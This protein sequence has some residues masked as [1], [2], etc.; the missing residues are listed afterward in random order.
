[1]VQLYI[2][3]DGEPNRVELFKDETISLTQ[4]ITN[5]QDAGKLFAD[6]S[7]SF[8]I[9]ASPTNNRIFK[10][11]YE[12]SVQNGFDHRYRYDGFI[13]INTIPFKFGGLQLN[14][15][16]IKD[17]KVYSYKVTFFGNVKQIKDLFGDDKLNSL[18]YSS[19]NHAYNASEILTRI[20]SSSTYA[21]RYPLFG[22]GR[23]L[24]YGGGGS[25]DV[26]TGSG[27]I[28]WNSLF[29]A[30]RVTD[31][32]SFIQTKYGITFNSTFFN[33]YQQW[34]RLWLY[35]KNADTP[36]VYTEKV[37]I[38]FTSKS[39]GW[40][41]MNLTNDTIN[42]STQ[43]QWTHLATSTTLNGSMWS[44]TLTVTPT[45]STNYR[46][47]VF[48]N[49]VQVGNSGDLSGTQLVNLSTYRTTVAE[50]I[51]LYVESE[52]PITF[53]TLLTADF[54]K[55]VP[56]GSGFTYYNE[57]KTASSTS[58]S[59]TAN[60]DIANFVPDIK[61]IDFFMG[62]VKAFNLVIIPTSETTFTIEPLE[63][64]YS[65]GK[66]Y[67]ITTKVIQD[68]VQIAP[69]KYYKKLEFKYQKSDNILNNAFRDLFGLRG[70]DYGD[71]GLTTDFDTTTETYTVELP[72]E[73]VMQTRE[74]DFLWSQFVNKDLQAYIPKPVIL[75]DNGQQSV[76]P[77]IK[78]FNGT[79]HDNLSTYMRFSNELALVPTSD[80]NVV[81]LNWGEE[82]STWFLTASGQGLFQ[83]HYE[84]QIT[85]YYDKATRVLSL[86]CKL[87]ALDLTTLTLNSRIIYKDKKYTINSI[88]SDL[89]TGVTSMELISDWRFNTETFIGSQIG[90]RMS[91][92]DS[93]E[94]ANTLTNVDINFEIKDF[95]SY[96]FLGS[97]NGW[98]DYAPVV[99]QTE[100]QQ[101]RVRVPANT[102]G[103]DR[104]DVL[105]VEYKSGSDTFYY[106]VNFKQ[107]A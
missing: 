59:T 30:I 39:S 76:S 66:N 97:V 44:L 89:T 72:F 93:V 84:S 106:Y 101:F 62:L 40:D 77:V 71:L 50:S 107:N 57:A 86:K 91:D 3:V 24:T 103:V 75:Y 46:V 2:Y 23:A 34:K 13:E 27:A 32:F 55:T 37:K 56:S 11:W 61:V 10:H 7:Q 96:S 8:T 87:S 68:S 78:L 6:Y 70:Y 21:V 54:Q 105:P 58:Q 64:W 35:C 15:V 36:T 14:G 102:T 90:F 31:V 48:R 45:S 19:L 99:D 9:P 52:T 74:G 81:S 80:A 49:G 29:P 12:N 69:P 94:T 42:S 82:F 5:Y 92:I 33:A 100:A 104:Y 67:D 4:N 60:I 83:R 18:D 38:N 73:N 85:T 63:L 53:T 95:D 41:G 47:L 43:Q 26:Q 16:E 65:L 79:G 28:H 1:M 98:L 20:T 51:E 88:N 17:R 22:N 25:T